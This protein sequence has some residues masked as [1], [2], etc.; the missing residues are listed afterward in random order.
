MKK[1]I[2]IESMK[3]S[4]KTLRGLIANIENAEKAQYKAHDV[5]TFDYFESMKKEQL[6]AAKS[7]VESIVDDLSNLL[8][9]NG[10]MKID[11]KLEVVKTNILQ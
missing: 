9:C 3:Q 8:A 4:M 2:S 11:E 6:E 1:N 5:N 7:R 10:C